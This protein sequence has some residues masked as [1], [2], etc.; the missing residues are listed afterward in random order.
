MIVLPG[1]SDLHFRARVRD[2]LAVLAHGVGALVLSYLVILLVYPKAFVN[3]ILLAY[4]ALYVSARFPFDESVMTNGDWMTQPVS[5][6]YLPLW[7]GAQL[8]LLVLATATAFMVWWLFVVVSTFSGRVSDS[9][10]RI[11]VAASA[12]LAQA[13]AL[14]L[15]AILA[16]SNIYNGTR[17]FLFVVPALCVASTIALFVLFRRQLTRRLQGLGWA[18]VAVGLVAPTVAQLGL[19]P[20]SYS[21]YNLPTSLAGVDNRWPADYWRQSAREL[22]QHL[23]A[24]GVESCAYEQYRKDKLFPCMGLP[25]FEVYAAERGDTALPVATDAQSYWYVMENQGTLQLPA[26]C[27]VFDRV[28]RR[29]YLSEVTIGQIARCDLAQLSEGFTSPAEG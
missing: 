6:T 14:P 29:L 25:T 18:L 19:F 7:F 4:E 16:Q 1:G 15:G 20:Y 9:D 28:T 2:A 27:E 13:L 8:P 10:R 24:E 5:W 26:G 12:V 3:P 22:V 21:Y 23:P 17:Q 11:A